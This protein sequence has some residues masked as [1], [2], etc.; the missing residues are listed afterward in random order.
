M[1][2]AKLL[3]ILAMCFAAGSALAQNIT[4]KGTITDANTG[5][6]IPFAS[7]VVKGGNTWATSQA[8]GTYSIEAPSNGTLSFALLGYAETDVAVN[9]R[10]VVNVALAPEFDQLTESVVIGYGVQ[11]KKLVTG[12]TVQVK[13]D[14]LTRLST[15][16]ALGALQSQTPG[17]TIT[18]N[19]GQPGQ[20]F[21]INIR[22]IGTIGDA[23]P[24]YVIDGVAGGDINA[25]NTSDIESIDV[26]KD[27]ASAAIYGARAANGVVLVTTK[28]GREGKV[29]TSY[30]GY[31]GWQ[32][33]AKWPDLCNAKEY[34]ELMDISHVNSGKDAYNWSKE[35]P[36]DL[37]NSINNGTWNGT[38][39]LEEMYNKGAMTQN[40]SVNVAGG[41]RDHSFSMGLSYTG[42]DGILGYNKI[43]PV[44]SQY[45]RY[46]F[47]IN[48]DNVIIRKND[49]EMLKAGET[50]NFSYGTNNGLREGDIYSNSLH[51]AIVANPLHKPYTYDENG[52]ITGFFDDAAR[53]ATGYLYDN[54]GNHPNPVASDYYN[55]HNLS[56]SYSLQGS[57]YLQFQPIKNLKF[58]TQFGYRMQGSSERSYQMKYC[59][60]SGGEEEIYDT[61]DQSLSLKQRFTW[62]NTASY[63]FD[64][65]G[66]HVFDVVAG[67][68]IEKWG[69]GESLSS[70]SINSIFEND[71]DRAYISNTKPELL[72]QVSLSGSPSTRGALASF[73]GRVNYS[74]KDKYLVSATVRADGS[75]NFAKGRRW[76][77]FPSVSAGWIISNEDFMQNSSNWLDF[78]KVR[79]SWGQNGNASIDNFQYLSTI[80]L[81][82]SAGYYFANKAV[83]SVGAIPD[84]LANPDVSWETSEQADLGIDARFFNS[85]LGLTVDGYVKTTKNWLVQ[86]PIAAVYGLSSPYV[87]GGDVRNS[88]I[89]FSIDYGKYDGEFNWGFK[90]N[91]SFNKNEV[92]RIANAEGII[93]GEDD[94]LSQGTGE[95]Y[96][97][98]VGY[99]IGYFYG[100]K[101]AG[102]YQNEAQ[103]SASKAKYEGTKP[104]DV[105]FV[106]VNNDG[107]IT[108]D[109]QTMIGNPHPDFTGG[110]N[111]WLTYKGF[112]LSLTGYG[113]FGQQIAKSYRSFFD[114]PRENYTRDYLNC[115][116]GEGTSNKLPTLTTG[117]D[118]NWS[119]IS[120][121]YIED[122]SYF[123]LSNVTLGYDF[124][125]L[126]K[127]GFISK[128]RLYV[129]AQNLFTITKYSG[130]DPEIGYGF[131]EDWVSGIDLGYYPSARTFLVGINFQF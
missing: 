114:R 107:Q 63:H 34:M 70:S 3:L 65:N 72:S 25:L 38:N 110:I 19:S 23:E 59:L 93:H 54:T 76:G 106:D 41:T 96:R 31:Y 74:M 29:V 85:S 123:K 13:G 24:L 100:Y 75:S 48:T 118:S 88:G 92:T 119:N 2:K 111:L 73:F 101:T 69:F 21:K 81:S 47:R 130:M 86:A 12:S 44:Y 87:N 28:Q 36:A 131:G 49:L 42:Q 99:P 51:N 10:A 58:K 39:W 121:I 50:L 98:Q 89:E 128:C 91:G 64:I 67:Q 77:V 84:V 120:D 43:D 122:G 6:A 61:V 105:I 56:K 45:R 46:T 117:L 112:D 57:V 4:V 116:H 62:E 80:K 7:V 82:S 66:E 79:A 26:L 14:E 115:W 109:D 102:I 129:A 30:D 60:S 8:D 103:V 35:L 97:V 71:F 40:H 78:L 90:L 27:A 94:V 83:P 52:N 22:G 104:G 1:K 20:G 68:S 16:Q 5:E 55:G 113:A 108:P 11:Q 32:F 95:M 17:V 53:S 126:M 15:G 127:K 18:Q 124:S 9:G 125:K 33:I 37:L